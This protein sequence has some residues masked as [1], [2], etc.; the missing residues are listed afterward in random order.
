MAWTSA[1]DGPM[2]MGVRADHQATLHGSVVGALGEGLPGA[3]GFL[4]N[5]TKG[6]KD[7]KQEHL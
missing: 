1:S 3:V 5:K 4:G 7:R 2:L 6:I